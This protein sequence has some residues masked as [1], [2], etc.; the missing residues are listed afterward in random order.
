M[1]RFNAS[2]YDD[3]ENRGEG[4]LA[5]RLSQ[6][7]RLASWG[8]PADRRSLIPGEMMR[9]PFIARQSGIKL[10]KKNIGI[11]SIGSLEQASVNGSCS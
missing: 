2:E 4:S 8:D 1:L 10:Y 6:S 3:R 5:S 7:D 11:M 9:A